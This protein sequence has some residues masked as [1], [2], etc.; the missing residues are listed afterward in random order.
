MGPQ[1]VTKN[2]IRIL[3]QIFKRALEA[4]LGSST[5]KISKNCFAQA[6][7]TVEAERPGGAHDGC[8]AGARLF[9]DLGGR[10]QENRLLLRAEE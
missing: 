7:Q 3:A 10:G 4:T 2:A 5:G 8:V 1:H 6:G 9:R